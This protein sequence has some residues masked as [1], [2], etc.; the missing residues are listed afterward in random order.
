MIE[1]FLIIKYI[2]EDDKLGLRI[3]KDFYIHRFDKKKDKK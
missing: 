3:N 2:G 1:N